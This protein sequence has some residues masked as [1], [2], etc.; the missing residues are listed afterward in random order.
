MLSR[1]I[2]RRGGADYVFE[3]EIIEGGEI[4]SLP[5][6]AWYNKTSCFE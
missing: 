6:I 3:V 2:G 4:I 1:L 5:A